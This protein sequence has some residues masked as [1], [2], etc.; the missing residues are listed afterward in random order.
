MN[1]RVFVSYSHDS[2]DHKQ[3]VR[4]LSNRLLSDGVEVI[5][6]Q[7]DLSIGEMLPH[8]MEKGISECDYVLLI[9]TEPFIQKAIKRAGGV[10]FE[11][12]VVTGEIVVSHNRRKYIPIYVKLDPSVAPPFLKGVLGIKI[13]NLF[14]YEEPYDQLYRAI[15][16]QRL[17]KPELGAIRRLDATSGDAEPFDL[18]KLAAH[19]HI[20]QWCWW[21][22]NVEMSNLNDISVASLFTLIDGYICKEDLHG[23]TRVGPAVLHPSCRRNCYPIMVYEGGDY[24]VY[25]N[26]SKYDR[27]VL[28]QGQLRY[29]FVEFNTNI[30]FYHSAEIAEETLLMLLLVLNRIHSDLSRDVLLQVH[31]KIGSSTTVIY[32]ALDHPFAKYQ[33]IGESHQHQE[34]VTENRFI[35]N[36]LN[37]ASIE[38]HVAD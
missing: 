37:I 13:D 32:L 30:P 8:F 11:I 16:D 2:E 7:Y 4:T 17:R 14:T 22:L 15:T 20:S 19:K 25:V 27:L 31:A 18:P 26:I 36:S 12:D 5:I 34:G 28:S 10:G 29:S 35:M 38:C 23:V 33:R 9:L 3:W 1:P 24:S 21:D 6:D